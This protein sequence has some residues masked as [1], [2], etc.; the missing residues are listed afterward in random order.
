M[1]FSF[2]LD[3]RSPAGAT[4]WQGEGSSGFVT[5]AVLA[6]YPA[7][8]VPLHHAGWQP[9]WWLR[10]PVSD[11]RQTAQ[12]VFAQPLPALPAG[13][14]EGRALPVWYKAAVPRE[15]VYAGAVTICGV[16]GEALVF[17]GRRRLVW[18][19]V[20]DAGQT[21]HLPVAVDVVP[22]ISEGDS[23]PYLNLS[24]DVS[25]VGAGLQTLTLSP[26]PRAPAGYSCWGIPPSPTRAPPSPTPPVPA[27][28]AGARCCPGFC[29]RGTAYP[30]TPIPA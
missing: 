18:R 1:E 8:Q 21:A 24:V 23:A 20:L 16:G 22:L 9:P 14:L 26:A 25:V 17:V 30:T 12:G 29:R 13:D 11:L 4:V 27:T 19:G 7:L 2:S 3:S 10:E 15:G 28:R 6:R 5:G